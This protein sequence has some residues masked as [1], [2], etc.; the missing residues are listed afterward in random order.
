MCQLPAAAS[1]NN[2][3]FLALRFH[4]VVNQVLRQD[5]SHSLINNSYTYMLLEMANHWGMY[6]HIC[7]SDL[8]VLLLN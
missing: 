8:P 1:K 4:S 3:D 2:I 7:L 5:C 6:V